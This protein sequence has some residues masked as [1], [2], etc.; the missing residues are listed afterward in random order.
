MDRNDCHALILF[1]L[2]SIIAEANFFVTT[3]AFVSAT[4]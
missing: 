2:E 1:D 3:R 4:N